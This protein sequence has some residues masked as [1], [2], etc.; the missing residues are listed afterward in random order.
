MEVALDQVA[1]KARHNLEVSV[2]K[3]GLAIF[4]D[5]GPLSGCCKFIAA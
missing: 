5:R 1:L 2:Q 3:L 4:E